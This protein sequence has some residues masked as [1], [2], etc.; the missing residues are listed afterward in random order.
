MTLSG[1]IVRQCHFGAGSET[2]MLMA[3]AVGSI[4]S[5]TDRT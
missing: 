4:G 3:L 5:A 1:L 2:V